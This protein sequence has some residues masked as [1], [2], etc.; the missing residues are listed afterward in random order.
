MKTDRKTRLLFVVV[1]CGVSDWV[2]VLKIGPV[3]CLEFIFINFMIRRRLTIG[4]AGQLGAREAEQ[5]VAY[6]VT[7]L[8]YKDILGGEC[9]SNSYKATHLEYYSQ[10][11]SDLG[12]RVTLIRAFLP[13]SRKKCARNAYKATHP[14][15]LWCYSGPL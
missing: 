8:I 6:K 9:A 14:Q 15:I 2:E 12:A 10:S 11:S 3:Q 5:V 1:A 4:P 13:K 7:Y